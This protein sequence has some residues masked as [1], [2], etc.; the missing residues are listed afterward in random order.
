MERRRR[1]RAVQAWTTGGTCE[2]L[3]EEMEGAAIDSPVKTKATAQAMACDAMVVVANA[4]LISQ[5]V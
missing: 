5:T 3:G 1:R 2:L 4:G